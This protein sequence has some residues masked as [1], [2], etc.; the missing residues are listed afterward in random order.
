MNRLLKLQQDLAASQPEEFFIQNRNTST[1]DP[2]LLKQ[3]VYGPNYDSRDL[4]MNTIR[5]NKEVFEHF[6]L[7][8]ASR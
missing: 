6:H 3:I 8:E 7:S 4:A 1:I 2:L 5:K